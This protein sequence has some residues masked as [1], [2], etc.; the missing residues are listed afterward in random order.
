V[1]AMEVHDGSSQ[2]NKRRLKPWVDWAPRICAQRWNWRILAARCSSLL[3]LTTRCAGS[4]KSSSCQSLVEMKRGLSLTLSTRTALIASCLPIGFKEK[5]TSYCCRRGTANVVDRKLVRG[6][7]AETAFADTERSWYLGTAT[8]AVRDQVIRH[9]PN[10]AV[11]NRSA[12][13][14]WRS[15]C[16]PW[17]SLYQRYPSHADA[18]EP[19]TQSMCPDPRP[20]CGPSRAPSQ[21]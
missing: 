1:P 5:L 3:E 12:R 8:D 4:K 13:A 18:Y 6:L 9:I 14:V 10:S 20:R 7:D 17:A 15:V 16:R 19:H 11:H 2:R 21:S